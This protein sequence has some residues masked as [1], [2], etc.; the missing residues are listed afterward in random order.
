MSRRLL[1]AP[2]ALALALAPARAEAIVVERV[3]AVVGEKAVLQ[4][5]L[6]ER[7]RPFLV[8]LYAQ[9]PPGPQRAAS[10][11][12]IFG[13]L[14]D[15]MVDEELELLAADRAN[16]TV[17]S[18][19]IDT[20]IRNI[21]RLGRMSVQ[22]LYD[23]VKRTTGMSEQEYRQ[24]IRRQVMEGKLLNRLV[25]DRIRLTEQEVEAMYQ[26]VVEQ[27]RRV[28]AYHPAWIVIRL[29]QNPT[30]Q[31][32]DAALAK[33]NGI[34]A[35]ARA[36]ADF[37]ALAMQHSE[38]PS[39]QS[40]GGDLD[41]RAPAGS[42]AAQAGKHR[43]LAQSLEAE[44]LKLEPG[45]VSAPFRF[46]DAIVVMHLISRQPSRYASYEAAKPEMIQRVRAE[47]LEVAKK[48]WLKDLRK[49]TH[50]DVRL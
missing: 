39:T 31:T 43:R 32:I 16:V 5:D 27:E 36:G 46:K 40:M 35:Q 14:L 38:D 34:V 23:D 28:R 15:K 29:G 48:K 11:S 8:Q 42:P 9:L 41:V 21:A 18:E 13:Q 17:S 19:D 20:S 49:R 10:E 47:K 24:E 26:R 12:K 33:A 30:Q 22:G 6:R 50:V 44:A 3:V 2:L 45:E 37:A 7:A 4:S 25:Q 1:F